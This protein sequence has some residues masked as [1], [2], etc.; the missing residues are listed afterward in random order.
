MVYIYGICDIRYILYGPI[1]HRSL[2]TVTVCDTKGQ[3]VK[4]FTPKSASW[5]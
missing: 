5:N 2:L 3:K 4:G 1:A